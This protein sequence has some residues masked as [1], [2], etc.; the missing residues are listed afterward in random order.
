MGVCLDDW[1]SGTRVYGNILYKANR[2]VL[3]GG[4]R[5][6]FTEGDPMFVDGDSAYR[7]AVELSDGSIYCVYYAREHRAIEAAVISPEAIKA[8]R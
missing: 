2:A 8:L 6:N 5:D 3:I 4:G 1:T 7:S